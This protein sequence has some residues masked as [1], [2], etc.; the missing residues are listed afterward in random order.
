MKKTVAF[1]LL[2]VIFG[3][4]VAVG[5][6]NPYAGKV[7]RYLWISTE[8]VQPAKEGAYIQ[9]LALF[10][11]ALAGTDH[12]WLAGQTIAGPG[13]QYVY[14]SMHEKFADMEPMLAA[15]IKAGP[16]MMKKNASLISEGMSAVSGM[17]S[18]I[19]ELQPE[20]SIKPDQVD[21]PRVTRWVVTTYHLRPG[22]GATFAAL[23]KDMAELHR[24]ADDNVRVAVYRVVAGDAGPVFLIIRHLKS[25]ADLDEEPSPSFRALMTP[26]IE[27][28]ATDVVKECTLQQEVAIYV[29]N[30]MLSNP[31][32]SYIAAN[33]DFW[34]VKTEEAA[35]PAAKK[36]KKPK[37]AALKEPV[38][39]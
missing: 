33:P 31:P 25:L 3:A 32:Q 9:T 22:A 21:L 1:V 38:K 14:V 29:V 12:Y 15:F 20:L 28:H 39:P 17:H 18:I 10:K 35:A 11:E 6:E 19:A 13:G 34:Q 23:L 27:K 5:G 26:L 30:P 16:E 4:V 7:P 2:L 8:T 37:P 24:K 36:M